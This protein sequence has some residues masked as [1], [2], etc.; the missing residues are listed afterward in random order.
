M[1]VQPTACDITRGFGPEGNRFFFLQLSSSKKKI[2]LACLRAWA[3]N[4]INTNI[5][6]GLS[7]K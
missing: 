7:A 3:N 4:V 6:K 5:E 2:N 1:F